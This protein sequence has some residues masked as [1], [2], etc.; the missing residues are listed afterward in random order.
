MEDT[1]YSLIPAVVMLGLVLLTRRI[2]L[3]LGTGIIV[4]ALLIHNFHILDSLK[5]IWHVF[6][7]IFYTADGW[8]ITNLYLLVFLILLGIIT[9]LMI[10]SGGS[11][12]FGDWAIKHIKTRRDAQLVPALLGLFIFIDDYFNNLAVGQV[13]RPVTDRYRVSR[14]KLAYYIDSTSAPITVIAPISSWGA[15]IIGILGPLF[16]TQG[17]TAYQ[18]LEAFIQ[19]IFLNMYAF[20][21]ILLVFLVAIFNINIGPMKIHERRAIETGHLVDPLKDTMAGRLDQETTINKNGKIRHLVIPIIVLA[22]TTVGAMLTT[23]YYAAPDHATILTMFE[24]TDVNLSLFIGGCLAALTGFILY[25]LLKGKKLSSWKIIRMGARS[26]QPAI[27]ILILAWM[28]GSIIETIDTGGFLASIAERAS[29]NASYLPL[30]I[31]ILTGFMALATGTSWGTFG[32]MLPIAAKVSV[33]YDVE[34]VL[35]AMASVLAGS[36]FGDHCSP[37]SDTSI[38]SSTGAGAN[39]IDHV[40]TQL[41]Y[42]MISAA[43]SVVGYL[44]FAWTGQVVWSLIITLFCVTLT[45]LLWKKYHDNHEEN[46]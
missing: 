23:G 26:M 39:H 21:A 30:L 41:P 3:S 11:L 17:I 33:V 44:V 4:G 1:I 28:I 40:M 24:H 6:S 5:E 8:N 13:A 25:G 7:G 10:A 38:L 22:V 42:V 34:L 18:P 43:A 16:A 29:L 35:P 36:V 2:L 12:A 9:V 14:A 31:F 19:M 20:A 27:G 46:E 45:A 37:I 32:I 15:F